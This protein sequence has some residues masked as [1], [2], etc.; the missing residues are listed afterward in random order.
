V[1]LAEFRALNGGV[2]PL[3][4]SKDRRRA[5]LM[6]R[7]PH[8]RRCGVELVY[9]KPRPHEPLPDNFAT[10]EH[11]NSRNQS[12]PRPKQGRLV[13]WCRKCNQDRGAAEVAALGKDELWRRSGRQPG[14]ATSAGKLRDS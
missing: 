3:R 9:F 1:D 14:S 8:C 12:V 13:L 6:K 7:D 4:D 5:D 10:L 11:V 2:I